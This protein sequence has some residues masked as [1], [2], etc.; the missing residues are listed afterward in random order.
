MVVIWDSTGSYYIHMILLY[1]Q[2]LGMLHGSMYTDHYECGSVND[3][4]HYIITSSHIGWDHRLRSSFDCA[5]RC[6][7][8]KFVH[9][10]P[11]CCNVFRNPAVMCHPYSPIEAGIS[12]F[13]HRA[14]L[15]L[16]Q[17][18]RI[19][20]MTYFQ[21]EKEREWKRER[22]WERESERERQTEREG[23]VVS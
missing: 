5:F 6:L 2:H 9:I 13:M 23:R 4:R 11:S 16:W 8:T 15:F 18:T 12:D 22:E 21:L 14:S 3:K 10:T 1:I 19:S 17:D 7:Q 20:F